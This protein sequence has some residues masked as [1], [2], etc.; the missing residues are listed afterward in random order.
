M[1]NQSNNSGLVWGSLLLGFG[2]L[3]LAKTLGWFHFDWGMIARFWPVLLILGG[4]NL[5][6]NKSNSRGVVTALFIAFTIPL[7]ATHSCNRNFG[8]SNWNWNDNESY[9]SDSDK[10]DDTDNKTDDEGNGEVKDAN[11]SEPMRDNI[12]DATLLFGGGAGE[13]R[14]EATT[15]QLFEADTKSNLGGYKLKT[16]RNETEKTAEI[17]FSM[18]GKKN[19]KIEGKD[20]DFD[21][22][23]KATVKLN[24]RPNWNMKFEI[25]AGKGDFDLSALKVKSVKLEAGAAD[26][27]LKLGDKAAAT[28]VSISSGVAS[29]QVSVPESV[30]CEVTIS[31]A[32][33][34]EDLDGFEAKG[35]GVYQTSNYAKAA[36]KI[37]IKFEG[38]VSKF[39]VNRY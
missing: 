5:I 17:D 24:D 11:F 15:T 9:N 6:L 16:K 7:F 18:D 20:N 10:N 14:I 34:A 19:V 25:G 39:E 26:I 3:L 23:N 36:K 8:N 32:L 35:N 22:D 2:L 29:V 37:V 33:N 30:G 31:G 4:L 1:N 13:F 27:D 28:D 12:A 21:F 38:G